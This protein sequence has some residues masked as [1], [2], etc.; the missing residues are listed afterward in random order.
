MTGFNL[1]KWIGQ[2]SEGYGVRYCNLMAR[3]N[4]DLCTTH[5]AQ[6]DAELRKLDKWLLTQ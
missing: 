5:R 3:P 6:V 2:A 1:C 4:D